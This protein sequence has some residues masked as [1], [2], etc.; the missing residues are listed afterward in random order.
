VTTGKGKIVDNGFTL[1]PGDLV[2]LINYYHQ[3][4]EKKEP[5]M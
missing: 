2:M 4:T 1:S 5:L 3:Q